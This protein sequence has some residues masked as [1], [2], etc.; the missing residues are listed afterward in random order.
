MPGRAFM[1]ELLS[2][3]VVGYYDPAKKVLYVVDGAP[4]E[5]VNVTIA[6]E[7]VHALQDQYIN[8]DSLEKLT[9]DSDRQT[10]MQTV[11]EGQATFA[12]AMRALPRNARDERRLAAKAR[13]LLGV[14]GLET[15][16]NVR[17][18]RLQH[19][20]RDSAYLCM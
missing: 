4:E 5:M 2:E 12:E 16:A 19:R 18:D 6:H 7:L 14:V 17:A 15:L 11:I 20:W 10:A 3:Q 13:V 1:L 9:Y 8:L